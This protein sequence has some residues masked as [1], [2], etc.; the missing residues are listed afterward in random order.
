MEH[1]SEIKKKEI[2][3]TATMWIKL[4]NMLNERTQTQKVAYFMTLCEIEQANLY[5][6]KKEK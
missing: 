3:I 5:K 4:E 1:Y 6:Q 2:L